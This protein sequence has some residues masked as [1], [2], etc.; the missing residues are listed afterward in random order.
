MP[1]SP[2]SIRFC[3]GLGL[4]PLLERMP[5]A[6]RFGGGRSLR[7]FSPVNNVTPQQ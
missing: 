6:R 7:G 1:P 2:G 3:V 5:G 4:G